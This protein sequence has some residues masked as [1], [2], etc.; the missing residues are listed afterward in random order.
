MSNKTTLTIVCLLALAT[1]AY[2]QN[3]SHTQGLKRNIVPPLNLPQVDTAKQDNTASVSVKKSQ[4][5]LRKYQLKR[6][7]DRRV[8]KESGLTQEQFEIIKAKVQQ[9]LAQHKKAAAAKAAKKEASKPA[10]AATVKTNQF[11]GREG[12]MMDV[13][14]TAATIIEKCKKTF[15]AKKN[16]RP[17]EQEDSAVDKLSEPGRLLPL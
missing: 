10:A 2:A 3:A 11:P 1:G 8:L 4:T 12:R 9:V 17:A 6:G 16:S 5:L 15:S 14:N 7:S 13:S